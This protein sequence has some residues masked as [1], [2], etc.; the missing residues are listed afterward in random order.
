MTFTMLLCCMY[1]NARQ[2]LDIWYTIKKLRTISTC[3]QLHLLASPRLIQQLEHHPIVTEITPYETFDEIHQVVIDN[4]SDN[5]SSLVQ[6]S[7]YGDINTT[8]TETNGFYVIMFTSEA[9]EFQD[10]T[11]IDGKL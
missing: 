10:S 2:T 4:I 8:D 5:M 7:K 6:S 9:Y 1:I 3:H 11:T